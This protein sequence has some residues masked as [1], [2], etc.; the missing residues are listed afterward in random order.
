MDRPQNDNDLLKVSFTSECQLNPG[1][2]PTDSD[3]VEI[4]ALISTNPPRPGFPTFL[5]PHDTVSPMSLCSDSAYGMHRADWAIRTP[6]FTNSATIYTVQIQAR[7]VN[8]SPF[9]PL[10]QAWLDDWHMELVGYN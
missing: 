1:A 4:R 6:V 9:L 2:T 5:E 3:W 8:N 10:Q 7:V